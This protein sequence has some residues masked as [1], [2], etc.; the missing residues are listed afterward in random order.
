SLPLQ[1][2]IP[3]AIHPRWPRAGKENTG[4]NG[5]DGQRPD[6]RHSALCAD[7]FPLRPAIVAYE[8]ACIPTCQNGMRLRRMG[9]QRLY[10]A[11]EWK[12]GAMP[13]PRLSS[14]WAIPYAP[15]GRPKTYTVV[16][17]HTLP[18]FVW[19]P[20][21]PASGEDCTRLALLR[22]TSPTLAVA[23]K[24]GVCPDEGAHPGGTGA[25]FIILRIAHQDGSSQVDAGVP[26]Q[27]E[28][29]ARAGFP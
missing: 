29:H 23:P 27:V 16:H 24:E 17:C 20:T 18:P 11:I 21:L 12:R 26:G 10:A 28:H 4:I 1:S 8:Q 3:R 2:T 19:A 13:Y 14:I 25:A 7:P 15:A 5:V 22:Q 6:R 9:D